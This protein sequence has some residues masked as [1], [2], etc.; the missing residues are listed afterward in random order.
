MKS[1]SEIAA[2]AK[3]AVSSLETVDSCHAFRVWSKT[4]VRPKK[5][6]IGLSDAAIHLIAAVAFAERR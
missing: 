2:F 4:T 1:W 3:N 5:L 6:A